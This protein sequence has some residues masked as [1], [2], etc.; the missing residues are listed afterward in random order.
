MAFQ[1]V[2]FSK[3][4]ASSDAYV[5]L[6]AV[7][8][9]TVKTRDTVLTV[10][11]LNQLLGALALCGAG[12]SDARLIAPS[13]RKVNP[14]Y[15]QPVEQLTAPSKRTRALTDETIYDYRPVIADLHPQSPVAL[16]QNEG[17][18]CEVRASDGG[19]ADQK[20]TIV[21]ISDGAPQ[22]VTGVIRRVRFTVT[23]S[24][25]AGVWTF[26]EIDLP[27]DLPVGQ[28][29]VVGARLIGDGLIAFRF[30][31]VGG[32]ARPGGICVPQANV[33]D[34]PEQRDGHLGGWFTFQSIQPPGVEVIA[35]SSIAST[36]FEG[37]MDL[38][39]TG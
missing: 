19:T 18:E 9:Q 16:T 3:N 11:T 2:A 29:Q 39:P 10:P 26:S 25:S 21:F 5:K 31:P 38:I 27:D 32:G 22:R 28:Y 15:I 4:V 37:Y 8:D 34:L 14:Q 23:T 33:N 35:D 30:V 1:I 7:T 36:T 12:G 13:L 24:A 6:N 20:T 17:L